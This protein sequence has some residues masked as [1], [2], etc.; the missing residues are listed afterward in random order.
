MKL[1]IRQLTYFITLVEQTT[2]T[3]ASAL[4]HISQPSLSA[5]IKKLEQEL[6]LQLIDREKRHV[7]MTKEGEILYQEAKKL[8]HHYDHVA[9]EMTRL[10]QQ[11]PMEISIG[12]IESTMFFIPGILAEFKTAYPNVRVNL[13]E[14]LSLTD[15][16]NALHHFDVQLAITNQYIHD[17]T[18]ETFPLYE[19]KL[20]ALLPYGH[21]LAQKENL[22]IN[23]LAEETFIVCKEGFQ[24]RADILDA[25]SKANATPNIHFEIERFETACSLV[26][27]NLGVTVIPKN[28]VT[29]TK[30]P[31]CIIKTI[32]DNNISRTVYLAYEKDRYLPPIARQFIKLIGDRHLVPPVLEG[33]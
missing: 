9:G 33:F 26:E 1:D 31:D 20:V 22:R 30:K 15:V 7:S 27:N 4:L 19:E 28:Y 32:H 18:I 13:Q 23:D 14:T 3:R 2:Y 6:G 5:A 17:E 29:F 24:T 10:K 16:K 21:H 25:F 8:R 12:L 11:G